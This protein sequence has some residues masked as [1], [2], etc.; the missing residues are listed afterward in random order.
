MVQ[1]LTVNL[2]INS[3]ILDASI[4]GEY[5]LN[6][7]VSYYKAIAKTYI[8]SLKADIIKYKNQIFQFNLK[9]KKIRTFVADYFARFGARRR[10]YFN[11]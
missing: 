3:D 7:I 6:S 5:D 1:V 9:S 8:P 11:W 10:C 2:T 4:K